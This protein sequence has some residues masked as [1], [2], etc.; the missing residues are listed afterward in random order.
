[1]AAMDLVN[2]G[3]SACHQEPKPRVDI[4][5]K[6]RPVEITNNITSTGFRVSVMLFTH[7]CLR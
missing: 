4:V 3:S 5:F 6:V 1:M 2:N 7:C